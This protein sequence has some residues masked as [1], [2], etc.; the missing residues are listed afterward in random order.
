MD[1]I[2]GAVLAVKLAYL[3]D[4]NAARR[5]HAEIYRSL[6]PSSVLPMTEQEGAEGIFHLFVI[7]TKNRDALQAHLTKKGIQTLVH[8]PVPIHLQPGY[9]DRGWKKG[10]F[11]AA[12]KLAEEILSLPMFPELTEEQIRE[13]CTAIASF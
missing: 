5:R 6:L 10:D 3:D 12:E 7:R 9:S 11:P 13:V 4:W 1:G 8:Y 2:Q